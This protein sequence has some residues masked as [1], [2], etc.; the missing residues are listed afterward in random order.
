MRHHRQPRPQPSLLPHLLGRRQRTDRPPRQRRLPI[1]HLHRTRQKHSHRRRGQRCR[2]LRQP[3]HL[4]SHHVFLLKLG[5]LRRRPHQARCRRQRRQR[6]LAHLHRRL[7]L[8]HLPRHQHGHSL[9]RRIRRP[10]RPTLRPRILKPAHALQH[11]Q[12]P[13][14]PHRR[15]PRQ[16]RARLQKR[17]GPDQCQNRLRPHPRPQIQPLCPE[18]D[19]RHPQQLHQNHHPL[20]PM[21]RHLAHPR[22][23]LL[24]RTRRRRSNRHRLPHR[25]S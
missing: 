24:D 11:A 13:P 23:P 9:R 22:H 6:L 16:P 19:R 2:H 1:H 17:L 3:R 18:N 12:R 20:V 10:P 8:R 4:E 15:R 21:G 5:P 14:H 25:Q 7:G